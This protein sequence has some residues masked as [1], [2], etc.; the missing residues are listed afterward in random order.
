MKFLYRYIN[1]ILLFTFIGNASSSNEMVVANHT[2][3]DNYQHIPVDYINKIKQML[4]FMPGESHGLGYIKGLNL[5]ESID[6]RY[7]SNTT[8]RKKDTRPFQL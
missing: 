7:S 2:I 5:L 4:L 8:W 3:V 6:N 1:V